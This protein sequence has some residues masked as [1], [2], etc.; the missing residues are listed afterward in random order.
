MGTGC[1]F[2]AGN[3]CRG[4]SAFLTHLNVGSLV[5]GRCW[6]DT[7]SDCCVFSW[8]IS[9]KQKCKTY[10]TRQEQ[11]RLQ[12]Q[13]HPQ[14]LLFPVAAGNM[15]DLGP[16]ALKIY[17]Q[18]LKLSSALRGVSLSGIQNKWASRKEQKAIKNREGRNKWDVEQGLWHFNENNPFSD[19]K[20]I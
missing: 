9:G 16:F 20:N 10:S 19:H 11:L 17:N 6:H 8:I 12:R 3:T 15:Q 18:D 5:R 2:Q 7:D 1:T 13:W 4:L 14:K